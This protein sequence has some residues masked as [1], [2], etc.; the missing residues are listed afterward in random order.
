M[1]YVKPLWRWKKQFP[2]VC[3]L[4]MLIVGCGSAPPPTIDTFV[5]QG[6]AQAPYDQCTFP[7]ALTFET[8]P[9]YRLLICSQDAA[10]LQAATGTTTV[11]VQLR[12]STARTVFGFVASYEIDQIG[13]WRGSASIR[14]LQ[15]ACSLIKQADGSFGNDPACGKTG[16][17]LDEPYQL[18]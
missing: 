6:I 1:R 4:L 12:H 18:K 5:M 11:T 15:L 10:A 17:P 14:S 16:P 7:F 2:A 8:A 9:G 13:R 3:A